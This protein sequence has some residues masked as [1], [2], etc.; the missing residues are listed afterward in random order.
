M[1]F[2][3]GGERLRAAG[4]YFSMNT[5]SPATAQAQADMSPMQRQLQSHR[6]YYAFLVT[7]LVLTSALGSFVN[8][9]YSPALPAMCTFFGCSVPLGQMG[10]TMGMIG[11]AL[12][13]IILGPVSDRCGRRPV[14]I[15][16]LVL[17]I[18][19]A[20]VSVFSPTIHMFNVCRLFQGIGASGG[21]FLARTIPAD[22]YSGRPL[23]KLMALTGA[24]NGIAPASAPVIG[25][26]TADA[27]GWK[28]VFLVLAAFALCILAVTPLVKESL[29][30]SRRSHG[31][32]S[33]I[34]AEYRV[35][36]TNRAFMVHIWLKGAALGLLF[37]YISASPFILQRLYGMSQTNY[38]LIIGLNAVF[39]AAG[40]MSA[41]KFKLLKRAAT[42]GAGIIAVAV[43]AGAWILCCVH[44]I[45]A[46]EAFTI[47]MSFGLGM[48]FTSANTLAMNEG[49]AHAGEASSLLG[50]TG[51]IIGAIVSPLVGMGNIL[52]STALV[53]GATTLLVVILAILSDRLPAD[54]NK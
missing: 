21:Y 8:D 23:A 36:V 24:I 43:A 45:W 17:F 6:H 39:A 35:L 20:G 34:L 5:S 30:V 7:F 54:L 53:Y 18:V 38:G 10:L 50:I 14:M 15:G 25:G 51:Y 19:S 13:Q 28:G 31:P 46:F 37:A 1:F 44:S 29:S 41:L 11:L 49:R 52:H 32:L 4:R 3:G 40:S 47:V 48:I 9:M 12:G 27:W 22:V 16:S 42:V 33:S 2:P 26:V